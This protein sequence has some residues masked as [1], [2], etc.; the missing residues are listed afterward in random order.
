MVLE[1]EKFFRFLPGKRR[2]IAL[3]II[4]LVQ[5]RNILKK[6]RG[7]SV[8]ILHAETKDRIIHRCDSRGAGRRINVDGRIEKD[9]INILIR[10]LRKI[11]AW[12]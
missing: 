8:I 6:Q 7:L 1:R 9:R 5:I 12:S 2:K 3:P 10:V 11:S 4:R